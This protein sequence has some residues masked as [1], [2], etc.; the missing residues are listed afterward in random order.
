MANTFNN[1]TANLT[2]TNVTDVYQAPA[3]AGAVSIVLSSMIA[4]VN[5]TAN[6]NVNLLLTDS[7]NN[8]LSYILFTVAVPQN[9]TLEAVSNKIVLKAGQKIRAQASLANYLNV[10]VSALEIT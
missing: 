3:S 5:G 2:T 9:T 6:S 10:T 8:I 4:N 1:A 7:S